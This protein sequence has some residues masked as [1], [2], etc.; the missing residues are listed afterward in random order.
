M[1]RLLRA[2]MEATESQ[3]TNCQNQRF[4]EEIL[5]MNNTVCQLRKGNWTKKKIR[6]IF[7]GWMTVHFCSNFWMVQSEFGE[8]PT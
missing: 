1:G 2:D 5:Q 8:N 6:K 3:I 4:A 7:P